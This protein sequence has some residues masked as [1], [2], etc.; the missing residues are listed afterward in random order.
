MGSPGQRLVPL[1]LKAAFTAFLLVLVPAYLH[2]YGGLVF[3]WFCDVALF[4]VLVGLWIES[5]LLISMAAVS[6]TLIQ[7][8]F[9]VDLSYHLILGAPLL[10]LSAFMFDT[11][12]PLWLRGLSLYHIW[13]P[14]LVVWLVSRLGYRRNAWFFQS[15]LCWAF[16]LTTYLAVDAPTGRAGNVNWIFGLGQDASS[17]GVS[18]ELWLIFLMFFLPVAVYFPT[19]LTL[20]RFFGHRA[21]GPDTTEPARL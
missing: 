15:M 9:V 4:T 17:V 13:F 3:L 5:A 1:P 6:I 19:H 12:R 16:L 18:R 10:G 20:A 21:T 14:V 8:G 7:L 2:F 11:H